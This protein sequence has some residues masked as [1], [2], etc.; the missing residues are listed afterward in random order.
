MT[1]DHPEE[2]GPADRHPDV[3]LTRDLP[4]E[5]TLVRGL[6]HELASTGEWQGLAQAA[7]PPVELHVRDAGAGGS[8]IEVRQEPGDTD[9]AEVEAFLASALDELER[10]LVQRTSDAS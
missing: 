10:R 8:T 5:P 7:S 1:P 6:L 3:V 2:S 9:T 4:A